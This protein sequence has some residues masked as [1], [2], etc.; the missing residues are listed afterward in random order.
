M[1]KYNPS[2]KTINLGGKVVEREIEGKKSRSIAFNCIDMYHHFLEQECKL[3]DDIYVVLTSQRPKRS[4]SQ[5]NFFHLYLS[6]IGKSSGF[7]IQELKC[8]VKET[9]LSKGISEIF[10]DNIRV[11]DDTSNLNTSEFCE[12]MNQIQTITEIPIPDPTPFN[13][14]ITMNEFGQLKKKQ[15]EQYSKMKAK[16]LN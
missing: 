14:P 6:L 10:G 9:I 7:T 1:T 8:W 11:V 4:E 12:M 3:N 15:H 5:N 16:N 13:L 2:H